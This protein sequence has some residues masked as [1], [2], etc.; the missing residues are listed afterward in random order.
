MSDLLPA[1]QRPTFPQVYMRLAV[2]MAQRSTCQRVSA[3]SGAV[4]QVGCVITSADWRQVLAV[5]YNGNAAGLDNGC[6]DPEAS[7]AC[8]CIHAEENAVISCRASR[9]E[10]KV[11]FTTHLP[12]V[13]CAKRIIQLGGVEMVYWAEPYRVTRGLELLEKVGIRHR[14]LTPML[15][16]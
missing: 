12:C 3:S 10:S 9:R 16:G 5:G 11:V 7:G 6:D 13:A 1:A 14:Q 8:G 15:V 4:M 2:T